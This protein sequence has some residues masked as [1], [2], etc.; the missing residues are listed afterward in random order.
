MSA[1]DLRTG[2]RI[3]TQPAGS[4]GFPLIGGD[5]VYTVTTDGQATAL[6]KLDG[7]VIWITQ[8][9]AYKN[10][11]KRKKRIAWSGPIFAGDRLFM[12]SSRGRTVTMNPYDGTIID[13]GKIGDSVFVS[14][15]IA[16]ETVYVL[17]D[18]AKLVALR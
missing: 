11:K 4:L 5:F 13:K 6:S 7:S 10:E 18:D 16:G 8:L 2:Q 17:T 3:W 12:A 1:F 9:P 15:I 14:P